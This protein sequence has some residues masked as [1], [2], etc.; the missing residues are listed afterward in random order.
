M[1]ATG[2]AA[3]RGD[4]KQYTTGQSDSTTWIA[5]GSGFADWVQVIGAGTVVVTT[6][7]D[8]NRTITTDAAEPAACIMGPFKALVSTTATRVRMGI[9][10]PPPIA[11]PVTGVAS[12]ST[13]ADAGSF[14]A[15]T[16]VEGALQELYQHLFSAKGG[17]VPIALSSF[18]EV[19]ATGDVGNAAAI[20]GVLAS[21][22]AP[23]LLG[24]ATTNDWAIQW[25]T[26]NADP[27]GVSFMLPA[28]FDD[29]ADATLDL[30]VSSG[31]TDAATMGI[32][33]SWDGGSEVTDS[34]DDASTKSATEH[35]ITATIAA[36]DIPSA[37]NRVTFRITP[38]THGT[39]AIN[40][41]GAR[42]NYKRKLLTS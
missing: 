33:S 20:G 23:I 12:G 30:V 25:A 41:T 29:T 4:F 42:L 2:A 24:K 31:S 28:D 10:T 8:N 40:L 13:I 34:A 1:P 9:G 39:N 27:I 6:E 18:R 17:C 15:Q 11:P 14:T 7:N 26:G 37:A 21:D 35:V 32:A 36:A 38:P 3:T 5:S 16:T 19:S 22:T